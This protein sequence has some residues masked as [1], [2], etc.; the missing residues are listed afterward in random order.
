M[1]CVKEL[2]RTL[3]SGTLSA[4]STVSQENW[5]CKILA[6]KCNVH[7]RCLGLRKVFRIA[8]VDGAYK[9]GRLK[10]QGICC[11][12]ED[13]EGRWQKDQQSCTL[14]FLAML[15]IISRGLLQSFLSSLWLH[16]A[17]DVHQVL[18]Q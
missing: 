2:S 1:A 17:C 9:R 12:T 15:R 4:S 16:S 5:C 10:N 11:R 18:Q 8:S 6:D 14:L 7:D 13:E 3:T